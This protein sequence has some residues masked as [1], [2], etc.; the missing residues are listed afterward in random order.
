MS[1]GIIIFP[2]IEDYNK[3]IDSNID[4]ETR[5]MA[6]AFNELRAIAFCTPK[7]AFSHNAYEEVKK[8]VDYYFESYVESFKERFTAIKVLDLKTQTEFITKDSLS[9]SPYLY[10]NGYHYTDLDE[11]K[12]GLSEGLVLLSGI[13]S[14][15][16]GM[17]LATPID[18]TPRDQ[19]QYSDGHEE[20]L[21][22]VDREMSSLEES[23]DECLQDLCITEWIIKYWDGHQED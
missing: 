23:L 6:N 14:R 17:C 5:F 20:P 18:I 22:Y 9:K 2:K 10:F 13:K 16:L 21:Y 11:T 4:N 1:S 8:L 12:Q 7:N 15:I 3:G 19:V